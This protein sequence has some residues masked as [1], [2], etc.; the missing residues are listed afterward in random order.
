MARGMVIIGGEEYGQSM[1]LA[2]CAKKAL[3]KLTEKLSEAHMD[4]RNYDYDDED[5]DDDD[6]DPKE[7]MEMMHRRGGS[8]GG[9]RMNRRMPRG[10]RYGY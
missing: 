4:E 3:C 8:R 9:G 5:D 10:G 7:Y 2:K 6:F 1:E